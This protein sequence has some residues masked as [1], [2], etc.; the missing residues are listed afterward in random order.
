MYR[1]AICDDL[2]AERVGLKQLLTDYLKQQETAVRFTEY[3]SGEALIIDCAENNAAFDLVF[4]D[5]FMGGISGVETAKELRGMGCKMPLVFVTTSP[6]FA[7]E[8]YEVQACGYLIKPPSAERLASLLDRLLRTEPACPKLA[9]KC[10]KGH[11]FFDYTE[12]CYLESKGSYLFLHTQDGQTVRAVQK[13]SEVAAQISDKRFLR[14]HQS[15][16]V[17]M[18]YIQKVGDDFVL[19]DGSIIPIKVRTHKAITDAYYSYFVEQSMEKN[20]N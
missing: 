18:D 3:E 13:L 11:R 4:L 10:G 9:L 19:L 6:D 12:I 17:N 16:L 1:I 20:H 8:G 7:L 15:Y 5:I 14:C 2:P